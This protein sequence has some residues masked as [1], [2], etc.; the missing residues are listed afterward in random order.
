VPQI[1][2]ALQFAHDQG[3]VHRDIKPE[4][5]L[6]DRRGRVKVADFGLAKI[7]GT[8]RNAGFQHGAKGAEDANEPGRRPALQ[9]LTD[10]SRVMGTPNYMSPEQITAPGEVDHRADIYA[11]GVVFYQMLTGKLPGK[12]LEAPSKKVQIDVRLDEIV[13]RALEKKPE[14][15]YQQ[16]SVLKTEVETIVSTPPVNP[17]L[18]YDEILARDY[19]LNV[20]SCL[21]R[22]LAF[23]KRDFWPVFGVTALIFWLMGAVGIFGGPL[24]GGLCLYF[25]KKIRGETARVETAF[26][27]VHLA[28]LQL[29]LAGLV[30]GI[31]TLLGLAC[32]VL[33][34]VFL[35]GVT[36]F[37]MALVIDKQLDFW[38]AIQL[39]VKTMSKHW[40]KFL[41]L[42]VVLALISLAGA[43]VFG[44]GMFLTTPLVF[45]AM[46]YAYEDIFGR[47]TPGQTTTNTNAP[48]Q[49]PS[50]WKVIAGVAIGAA[51]AVIF[52]ALVGLLA[53]VAIPNFVKAHAQAQEN[54]RHAAEILAAQNTSFGAITNFY[55]GQTNFPLGDS[56]E[57]TSIARNENQMTVKG[58]YHLVS[59]DRALLALYITTTNIIRVP[60]DATQQMQIAKGQGDFELIDSHLVPGWPHVSMYPT[61]G[62]PFASLYFGTKAEAA[63]ESA[64]SWITNNPPDSAEASASAYQILAEQPPVV[65]ET[66]PV[67]GAHD[68]ELGE[69]EIRVR[70]SKE[71]TD[72]SWSWS[73]AWENSTPDFIGQPHYET[74]GRTCVVKVKLEPGR[75]YAW[76]L[77]SEKFL[78]FRDSENRPAIPY[79]LIFQTKSW[80][81]TTTN[82]TSAEKVAELSAQRWLMS[83]DG[84]NYAESWNEASS[85][86]RSV[87][88]EPSWANSMNTFRQPLGGLVARKIKSAQPMMELPG[89]P[90]GQYVVMQF[91]TSF[92]NKKSA[93]ETVTFMLEKD[94][95]WK[96]AGYFIK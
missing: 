37:A 93:I 25:L 72:G 58:H 41:G 69:T 46:M 90:D 30:G 48:P 62:E 26:S 52:I 42:M 24:A 45:G 21:S 51:A 6:L 40:G 89:A 23:F 60:T 91:E 39:S 11:L 78:N 28:L 36:I 20:R 75:T 19:D 1:C 65:V 80:V 2:D 34:G 77:N 61:N 79:L 87:V 16:A 55:I 68:V 57:I 35:A 73:S 64:S 14:L 66:F 53:A 83:I 81:G 63:E 94:G 8:E 92:A 85:F 27:G 95:Q 96:S 44:F 33:P 84:G 22:A 82:I 13:L 5:I 50:G 43:L 10:A 31:F 70:F 47:V 74:D 9:E 3:I 56:I 32:L 67:S 49:S 4:N 88:T 76:W 18:Y 38:P 54:A 17:E 29:F 86:F 71:M 7:V 12:K 59:R 15:R